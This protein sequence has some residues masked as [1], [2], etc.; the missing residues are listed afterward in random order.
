M[1]GT[2]LKNGTQK[3]EIGNE[4]TDKD[5]FDLIEPDAT[6]SAYNSQKGKITYTKNGIRFEPTHGTA[7]AT[8]GSDTYFC[9]FN[10]F[11]TREIDKQNTKVT[12]IDVISPQVNGSVVI[13]QDSSFKITKGRRLPYDFMIFYYALIDFCKPSCCK[14][15]EDS[16]EH[17]FST[18]QAQFYLRVKEAGNVKIPITRTQNKLLLNKN[19]LH[20]H[21][22][23]QAYKANKMEEIDFWIELEINKPMISSELE[24]C[25]SSEATGQSSDAM[26][27]KPP[28]S[29]PFQPIL[30]S[31]LDMK[32][33]EGMR[34]EIKS[35]L[36]KIP[37]SFS[38]QLVLLSI[39]EY[40]K[41]EKNILVNL[42]DLYN[43]LKFNFTEELISRKM[44]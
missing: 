23:I 40:L 30:Y 42:E 21:K 44:L 13:S 20:N 26:R 14:C 8:R 1:K 43:F 25:F 11:E 31:N 16:I 37:Y 4:I 17:F 15:R 24:G 12:P 28:L 2:I 38:A 27:P 41:Q 29:I 36:R 18:Y 33:R 19:L 9:Y 32:V 35:Q 10:L 6:F 39:Q 5:K 34:E 22:L 7:G 3:L